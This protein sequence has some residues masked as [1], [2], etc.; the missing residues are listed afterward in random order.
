MKY[1]YC[2]F[3]SLTFAACSSYDH[4][5]GADGRTYYAYD[6][7]EYQSCMDGVYDKCGTVYDLV[8]QPV[9]PLVPAKAAMQV[10]LR[11]SQPVEK[12]LGRILFTC[13]SKRHLVTN[14]EIRADI[15][16]LKDSMR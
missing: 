7:T 16:D 8:N 4:A 1:L 9:M 10:F 12:G 14:A 2:L 3:I 15:E 13:E 5:I 11:G 6:C